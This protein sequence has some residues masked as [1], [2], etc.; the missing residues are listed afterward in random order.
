MNTVDGN[1]SETF[2]C[3]S[4]KC[5]KLCKSH[6]IKIS[7]TVFINYRLLIYDSDKLMIDKEVLL[8]KPFISRCV[9]VSLILTNYL[10]CITMFL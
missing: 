7:L 10:Q 5:L 8:C 2:F 3:F 1:L 6:V 9:P 4:I